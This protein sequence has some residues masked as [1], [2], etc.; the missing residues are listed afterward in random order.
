MKTLIVAFALLILSHPAYAADNDFQQATDKAL[1]VS[2]PVAVVKALNKEIYRG[3]L[4]AAQQLGLMYR[5]GK[6]VS[7]DHAMARKWLKVAAT[8]GGTRTWYR[9]GLAEAQYALGLLLRDG[10]GGKVDAADAASWFEQAAEQGE[11]QAQLALAQMQLQGTGIRHD[12][13]RAY[14]WSSIAARTLTEAA[15]K[16]AEQIRDQAQKQ[17]TPQQLKKADELAGIW[18]PKTN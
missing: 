13:E 3:N 14:R 17:L 7:R 16:E 4:V 12:P 18:V 1:A 8:P 10:L 6:V 15:Q 2:D 9:R 11:G 5:D